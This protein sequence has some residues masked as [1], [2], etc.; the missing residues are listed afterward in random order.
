MQQRSYIRL[1]SV[2][3]FFFIDGYIPEA[4]SYADVVSTCPVRMF[5]SVWEGWHG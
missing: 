1:Y 4:H 3:M 2:L 5:P